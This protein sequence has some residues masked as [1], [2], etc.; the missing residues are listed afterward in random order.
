MGLCL[1]L[2]VPYWKGPRYMHMGFQVPMQVLF[3][4]LVAVSTVVVEDVLCRFV[5]DTRGG[6][7]KKIVPPLR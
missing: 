1:S 5:C 7:C 4:I 3:V 2:R 6:T